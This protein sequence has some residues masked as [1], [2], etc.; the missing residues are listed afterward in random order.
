MFGVFAAIVRGARRG[1]LS[2]KKGNKNYYKG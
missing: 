1:V 2:S